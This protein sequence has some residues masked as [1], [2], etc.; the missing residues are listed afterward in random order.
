MGGKGNGYLDFSQPTS[1][2]IDKEGSLYVL[3]TG[4]NRIKLLADDGS[5]IG[6]ITT[7]GLEKQ[8]CTGRFFKNVDIGVIGLYPLLSQVP[9]SN[10]VHD[11][12]CLL[13]LCLS[14]HDA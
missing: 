6:H 12:S 5:F 14:R 1:V 11:T 3:D 13:T 2:A 8:G 9:H 10:C 7:D 4:N